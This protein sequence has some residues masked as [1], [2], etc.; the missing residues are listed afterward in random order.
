MYHVCYSKN[1]NSITRASDGG[2]LFFQ[3][4]ETYFQKKS[5][6]NF[7]FVCF[8]SLSVYCFS[9]SKR[10]RYHSWNLHVETMFR[11]NYSHFG[12]GGLSSGAACQGLVQPGGGRAGLWVEPSVLAGTVQMF[13]DKGNTPQHTQT[14][15]KAELSLLYW[16]SAWACQENIRHHDD[17]EKQTGVAMIEIQSLHESP[18]PHMSE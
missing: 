9:V 5:Q 13:V 14:H 11:L 2:G 18:A 7:L 6:A 8:F 4:N 17:G 16:D 10:V 3:V 12:F 1:L 15:L